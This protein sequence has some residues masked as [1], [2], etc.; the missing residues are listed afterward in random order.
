M[1]RVHPVCN[2]EVVERLEAQLLSLTSRPDS[3]RRM[4]RAV[5]ER[6]RVAEAAIDLLLANLI[7]HRIV[8]AEDRDAQWQSFMELAAD[9]LRKQKKIR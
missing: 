3:R 2:D 7:Q 1:T 5:I 9:R 8:D 6:L 4:T